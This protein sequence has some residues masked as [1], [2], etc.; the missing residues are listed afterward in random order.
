MKTFFVVKRSDCRVVIQ[1]TPATTNEVVLDEIKAKN[2]KDARATLNSSGF[3]QYSRIGG[4]GYYDFA[5]GA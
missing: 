1:S 2:W 3:E 5:N 4:Y